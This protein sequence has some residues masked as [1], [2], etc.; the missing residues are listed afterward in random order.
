VNTSSVRA[1]APGPVQSILQTAVG[2][3][4]AEGAAFSLVR[5]PFA[6]LNERAALG[7]RARR[8]SIPAQPSGGYARLRKDGRTVASVHPR[9]GYVRVFFGGAS[10]KNAVRVASAA[11]AKKVA[12]PNGR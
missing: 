4:M 8:P 9:R 3:R 12:A 10:S 6:F 5:C 11:E 1:W 2:S 7:V